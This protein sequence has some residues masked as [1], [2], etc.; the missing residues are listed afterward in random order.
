MRTYPNDK[1]DKEEL[2]RLN[3]EPW[4]VKLLKCNPEYP[5]WGNYEDYMSGGSGWDKPCELESFSEMW[6]LDELNEVVNFYFEIC[7]ENHK[8]EDCEGSGYNPETKHI[9]DDWYD[10][11]NTGRR[12]R[13]NITQDEVEA[14]WEHNRLHCDFKEKPTAEQVNAWE[15]GRGIGHDSINHY[16]CVEQ[17]AKRL[18]VYGHCEKCGGYGY[19]FDEEKAHLELQLW[20]LHPR[21]GCSRGVRI[22]NILQSDIPKVIEYLQTARKRND[23][24]F[25]KIE[26]FKQTEVQP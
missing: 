16:I 24:R 14:L 18:G 8:C 17:R 26:D 3:A 4:M 23:E 5:F 25:A 6:E 11:A 21:K 19:I 22:K 15:K 20:V 10:F 9:S 1:Y 13:E 12:W 2:E 7:R